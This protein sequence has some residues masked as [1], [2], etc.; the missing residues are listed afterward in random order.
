MKHMLEIQG[1]CKTYDDFAL[2]D[3][4]LVLPGGSIL[5]LIG[6]NSLEIYLL[7]VSVFSEIELWR[8]IFVFGPSNRLYWLV[9]FVLN[10]ALG[11]GLHWTVEKCRM[12][13]KR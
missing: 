11:V 8:K 7:N 9:I 5:G 3:V 1:L 12:E 10:V 2:R 4:N 13:M 6:E